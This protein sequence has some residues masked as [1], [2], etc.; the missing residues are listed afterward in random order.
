LGVA[1]AA[2]PMLLPVTALPSAIFQGARGRERQ[3]GGKP[4]ATMVAMQ[5]SCAVLRA[6][7]SLMLPRART[8]NK[9]TAGILR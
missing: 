9:Q 6:E 4:G 1:P 8:P 3:H 5:A 7:N 2:R